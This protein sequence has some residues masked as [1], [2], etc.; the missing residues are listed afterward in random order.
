MFGAQPLEPSGANTIA[1]DL[2]V[3]VTHERFRSPRVATHHLEERVVRSTRVVE[4]QRRD[5]Q[6]F[7]I[8]FGGVRRSAS[9]SLSA[10]ILVMGKACAERDR[11]ALKEDRLDQRDIREMSAPIVWVVQDVNVARTHRSG[12]VDL[13]DPIDGGDDHAELC[14]QSRGLC[15]R[16]PVGVE[17]SGRSIQ[18]LFDDR[19][20]G[21]LEQGQLHLVGD[22]VKAIAND[23]QRDWVRGHA[24][25]AAPPDVGGLSADILMFPIESISPV[26]RG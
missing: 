25:H 4:L 13:Y 11:F 23:L 2:G 16:S 15:Q 21:T 19:R 24:F 10:D 7:R 6:A 8:D 26:H 5:D 20:K 9:G 14:R 12:G 22:D 18:R 3:D 17:E 1:G